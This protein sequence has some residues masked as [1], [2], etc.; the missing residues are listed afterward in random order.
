MRYITKNSSWDRAKEYVQWNTSVAVR[1]HLAES[2]ILHINTCVNL[3]LLSMFQILKDV[4]IRS[5]ILEKVLAAVLITYSYTNAPA[6][7]TSTSNAKTSHTYALRLNRSYQCHCISFLAFSI[8]AK[9]TVAHNQKFFRCAKSQAHTGHIYIK[10]TNK[11]QHNQ[12]AFVVAQQIT[13]W[14][15]PVTVQAPCVLWPRLSNRVIESPA[16]SA[17]CRERSKHV[18]CHAICWRDF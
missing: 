1:Y 13:G 17:S 10:T 4:I 9:L 3:L 14:P 2:S 12:H 7:A 11:H 15:W 8:T 5:Q 16:H 18:V 6:L